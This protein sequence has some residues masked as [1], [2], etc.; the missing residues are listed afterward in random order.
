[1]L[2]G[3]FTHITETRVLVL[4][5]CSHAF[6]QILLASPACYSS[7]H[8]SKFFTESDQL[9]TEFPPHSTC[10]FP[11]VPSFSLDIL[12]LIF[13]HK[14]LKIILHE[15]KVGKWGRDSRNQ[16]LS[17]CLLPIGGWSCGTLYMASQL[18]VHFPIAVIKSCS[19]T[20]FLC[21][22]IPGIITQ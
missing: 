5:T 16:C 22:L 9:H 6:L 13:T 19:Y 15:A 11:A 12:T 4:V 8:G 18:S 7:H 10:L 1:M 21:P 14:T 2:L 3:K 20:G 17:L